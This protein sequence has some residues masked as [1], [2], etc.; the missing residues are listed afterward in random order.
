VKGTL[1][2]WMVTLGAM[3]AMASRSTIGKVAAMWLPIMIFFAHGYEHSVVNMFV[4]PAGML[5]GGGASLFTPVVAL[6]PAS[7]DAG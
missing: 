6:E 7:G 4:L 1:C 2:N 3:L 5:L